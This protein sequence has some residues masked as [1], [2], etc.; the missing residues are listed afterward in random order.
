M[1]IS[2]LLD[3]IVDLGSSAH[4]A[5]STRRGTNW[6]NNEDF[7]DTVILAGSVR[8]LTQRASKL[9][10]NLCCLATLASDMPGL[11]Q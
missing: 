5:D 2:I 1:L 7:D 6:G 11:V 8:S 3:N 10:C 9:G 4:F